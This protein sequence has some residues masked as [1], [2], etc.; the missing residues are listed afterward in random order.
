LEKEIMHA[1]FASLVLCGA[2]ACSPAWAEQQAAPDQVELKK[3]RA[4]GGM[5]RLEA[6]VVAIDHENRVVTLRGPKGNER[7]FV[8][9]DEV[10]NLPQVNVGDILEV[11][12]LEAVATSISR[13]PG[14]AIGSV[15]GTAVSRAELGHKPHGTMTRTIELIGRISK[16]DAEQ[17]TVVIRGKE[18]SLTVQAGEDVD[19][20]NLQVG[21][22][23]RVEYIE[24]LAMTVNSPK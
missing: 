9:S 7:T 15:V 5:L 21:D 14:G 24:S 8:V 11:R 17:R 6:E 4:T 16:I 1:K 23:V 20:S 22:T 10:R 12:Y 13:A 2:L 18:G 3:A 19:I